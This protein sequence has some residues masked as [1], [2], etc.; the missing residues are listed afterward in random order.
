MTVTSDVDE[1]C[2]LPAT[3]LVGL[4]A[5]RK[6]SSEELTRGFLERIARYDPLLRAF[7]TVDAERALAEARTADASPEPTG[8]LHGVPVAVKDNIATNALRT[9]AGSRVLANWIPNNDA[10]VVRRLKE[11]GA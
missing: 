5:A 11:A 8:P 7:I 1:P 3:E 4:I 6:V 2:F 9:T 10:P